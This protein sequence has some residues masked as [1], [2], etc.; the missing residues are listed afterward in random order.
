MSG[1]LDEARKRVSKKYLGK[2]GIHGVGIRRSRN[3]LAVYVD[4]GPGQGQILK[5]VASEA[6]PYSVLRIECERAKMN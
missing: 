6:A 2:A 4:P 1:S 5:E 3:A